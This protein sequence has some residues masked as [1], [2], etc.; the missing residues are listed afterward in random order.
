MDN[1]R[2]IIDL[3]DALKRRDGPAM[4]ALYHAEA[5]FRDPIFG[6]L[7]RADVVSMW[8]MLCERGKDLELDLVRSGVDGDRGFAE[9]EAYYTFAKTGNKIHNKVR[10]EFVFRGGLIYQQTDS[11]DLWAWLR[12][13]LGTSGR[14]LGWAPPL[15][16]AVRKEAMRNLQTFRNQR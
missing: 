1:G 10:S 12:M 16:S 4:G 7:S 14:L 13:A 2:K 5:T 6:Q 8:H 11:F 15:R 9:W 3:Y